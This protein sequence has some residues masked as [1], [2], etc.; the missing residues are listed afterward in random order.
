VD[1]HGLQKGDI[2]TKIDDSTVADDGQVILRGDELIQH[3]YLMRI[4]QKDE[5]VIFTVFRDGKYVVCPPYVLRDIRPIIPRWQDVDYMP[6]YMLLGSL[7]LLPMNLSM[8]NY[9]ACGSLLKAD[10]VS[11]YRKWPRECEEEGKEGLV[12]E[13]T[14]SESRGNK[15]A[16]RLSNE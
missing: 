11:H 14:G 8:R 15:L 1:G 16:N 10:C 13:S 6:N 5:P 3:D 7:V 2:L 12:G 9:N 4:K